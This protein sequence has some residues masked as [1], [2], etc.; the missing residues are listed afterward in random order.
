MAYVMS[1]VRDVT[2]VGSATLASRLLGFLRDIGV[3][4]VLGAGSLSDAYFAAVQIP[5]LFRRLVAGELN[6]AFVPAW[7]RIRQGSGDADAF[8][9]TVFA[10]TG[11]MLCLVTLLCIVFAPV[12]VALLLP[13]FDE[14]GVRFTAAV[15]FLL[16]SSSPGSL[17]SCWS[18]TQSHGGAA[19]F[20]NFRPSCATSM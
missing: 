15:T 18:R 16:R 2:S 5:N 3:A 17:S 19:R 8:A 9:W 6:A 20:Q 13:G 10:T 7:M 14:G 4:A 1:V 12:I 11:L